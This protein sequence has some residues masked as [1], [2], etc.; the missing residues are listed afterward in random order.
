M[1]L[2]HKTDAIVNWI[3]NYQP[4]LS[5]IDGEDL[6]FNLIW[7][8]LG[9]MQEAFMRKDVVEYLDGVVDYFWVSIWRS[10]FC[11]K[12][13]QGDVLWIITEIKDFLKNICDRYEDIESV[14]DEAFEEVLKSNNSKSLELQE[15]GE[16]KN[17]V[18]KWKDFVAP[19]LQKIVNKYNLKFKN[20]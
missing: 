1:K 18:I 5:G 15:S 11:D 12:A 17:K 8:E 6:Y 10:L 13:D 3:K 19:D 2:D 4:N 9:E 7:E 20:D 16:K 14:F